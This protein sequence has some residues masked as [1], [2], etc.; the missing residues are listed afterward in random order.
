MDETN[1]NYNFKVRTAKEVG[2]NGG[3]SIQKE[4][5][6]GHMT[7]VE[8]ISP[9]NRYPPP[10]I[11]IGNIQQVPE[12]ITKIPGTEEVSFAC[13]DSGFINNEIFRSW[14]R[15]F[16]Q[17][18]REQKRQGYFEANEK[19]ILFLDGHQ[20][21]NDQT[22]SQLLVEE[23]VTGLIFP[24][25]LTHLIQPLDSIVFRQFRQDYCR[26][27]MR[28][29]GKIIDEKKNKQKNDALNQQYKLNASEKRNICI[30][31]ALDAIQMASTISNRQSS[32]E[33]TGIWPR[34]PIRATSR[35]DVVQDLSNPRYPLG[36]YS[37]PGHISST[38][39]TAK[40]RKRVD[41]NDKFEKTK[42]NSFIQE[43]AGSKRRRTDDE[44]SQQT[45]IEDNMNAA[46]VSAPNI[47]KIQ[48]KLDNQPKMRLNAHPCIRNTKEK[49]KSSINNDLANL[50]DELQEQ[51]MYVRNNRGEGNCM[52]Y[53][54]NDQLGGIY[55][56]IHQL[57]TDI[58]QYLRLNAERYQQFFDEEESLEQ[59]A[60]RMSNDG[61]WGDGRLFGA[62]TD[63][64]ECQIELH[65]PGEAI[66][67]EGQICS[68]IIRLGYVGRSH[69][70][71]FQEGYILPILTDI[72]LHSSMSKKSSE[73]GK[74]TDESIRFG[75]TS[76][77]IAAN[78]EARAAL[79]QQINR[80][81]DENEAL[82]REKKEIE[83]K[84]REQMKIIESQLHDEKELHEESEEKVNKLE[85][86]LK[87]EKKE[88]MKIVDELQA[89]KDDKNKA[90]L[91]EKEINE[92]FI[93]KENEKRK[94]EQ[95]L[96]YEIED[97]NE[98]VEKVA[99]SEKKKNTEIQKRKNL[100]NEK[101]KILWENNQLKD[102][103]ERIQQQYEIE[104]NKRREFEMKYLYEV[105]EKE[106]IQKEANEKVENEKQRRK[107]A[108]LMKMK[109]QEEKQ[110][111]I[112]RCQ[113]SDR[114]IVEQA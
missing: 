79:E 92:K 22:A 90:I 84:C 76:R 51:G 16:C 47:S 64:F 20:S 41:C 112:I 93:Q 27:L 82:R 103:N 19:I 74:E 45:L 102:E 68:R 107:D 26:Q 60:N 69:Y 98:A 95:S 62:I 83:L 80:L 59:Y 111:A 42:A 6:P 25:A 109:E 46:E 53:A 35:D 30:K 13:S 7:L 21:R 75:E 52:F 18:K 77:S 40:K 34:N 49:R 87:K 86:L 81:R 29:R 54:I 32:F 66:F 5:M 97:K 1:I 96:R 55:H 72:H 61:E 67:T 110:I 3:L 11:I 71:I 106:N 15:R 104:M 31:A 23:G 65:M 114:T 57:R 113:E 12:N 33:L 24:G 58:V 4:N 36:R 78:A 100:E 43:S 73:F 8:T 89:E 108:E 17:W 56:D 38:D 48:K 85:E 37:G 44:S 39:I 63:F 70:T 94:A 14:T 28:Q 91:R 105:E 99:D 10:L 2:T 88:K 50:N 101:D 9:E